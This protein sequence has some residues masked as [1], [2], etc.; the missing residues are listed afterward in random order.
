MPQDDKF[1]LTVYV[2]KENAKRIGYLAV[3]EGKSKSEIVD[4]ILTEKFSG[5]H[6]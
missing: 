6:G 5:K 2:S 4:E 3:D 1:K